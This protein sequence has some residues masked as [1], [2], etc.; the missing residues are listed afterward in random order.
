MKDES[1]SG[2]GNSLRRAIIWFAV[3]EALVVAAVLFY[4]LSR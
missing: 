1:D 2:G 3:V 4:K